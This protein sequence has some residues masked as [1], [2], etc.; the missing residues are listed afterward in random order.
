[1]GIEA[2]ATAFVA[3]QMG[4]VQMAAAAKM[5]KMNAEAAKDIAQVLEAAQENMQTLANA[6][7]GIGG[8]LDISI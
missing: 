8:N 7:A 4:Q 5:L 1:M 2:L 6:A 3:A